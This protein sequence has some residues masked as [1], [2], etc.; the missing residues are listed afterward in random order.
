FTTTLRTLLPNHIITHAPQAPYFAS[1]AIYPNGAYN[2]VHQVVGSFISWY[3]VQFYNQ[4]S[5]S[6][7]TYQGLFQTSGGWCPGTSVN[8]IVTKGVPK[9][10]VVVGKPA[11]SADGDPNSLMS[12]PAL[13][14]AFMSYYKRTGRNAGAFLWQYSSDPTG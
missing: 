11:T 10:K 1:T 12:G 7:N 2:K 6:Y 5:T 3:N 8:E 14:D 9:H 13:S 4:G